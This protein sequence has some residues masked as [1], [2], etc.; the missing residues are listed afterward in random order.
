M[1]CA[2]VCSAIQVTG[3]RPSSLLPWKETCKSSGSKSVNFSGCPRGWEQDKPGFKKE[4][5]RDGRFSWCSLLR[6]SLPEEGQS[7]RWWG[8]QGEWG[9]D[10]GVKGTKELRAPP[11][12]RPLELIQSYR[13]IRSMPGVDNVQGSRCGLWPNSLAKSQCFPVIV[14]WLS[15]EPSVQWKWPNSEICQRSIKL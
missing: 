7:S 5:P 1:V 11:T 2:Y 6:S 8:G 15:E 12:K 14:K 13:S 9:T 4:M 3:F 10:Q